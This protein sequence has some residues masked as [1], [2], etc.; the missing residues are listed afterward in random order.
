LNLF[1]A[2]VILNEFFYAPVVCS[3]SLFAEAACRELVTC[4]M[5]G[6]TLAA[7]PLPRAGLIGAGA[8]L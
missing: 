4:Q 1:P 3:F 5:V 8:I 6:N 7:N 2:F